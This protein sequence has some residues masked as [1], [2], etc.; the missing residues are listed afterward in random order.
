[1]LV[2]PLTILGLLSFAAA[3]EPRDPTPVASAP[4]TKRS[5]VGCPTSHSQGD[6]LCVGT[7]M[8]TRRIK[9][10]TANSSW[11]V[12]G[13]PVLEWEVVPAY[14]ASNKTTITLWNRDASI[15]P[16]AIQPFAGSTVSLNNGSVFSANRLSADQVPPGTGYWL[17]IDTDEIPG[18]QTDTSFFATSE[19]FEIKPDGTHVDYPADYADLAQSTGTVTSSGV[20]QSSG[21]P[22]SSGPAQ[23]SGAAHSTPV[24]SS[25]G[26]QTSPSP[27]AKPSAAAER[28]VVGVPLA[29]VILVAVVSVL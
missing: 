24:G 27:T 14:N 20:P 22:E 18:P 15:L 21:A 29:A 9:W 12:G 7:G 17:Q 8:N 1:M 26:A 6:T 11:A 13:Y 25:G 3:L 16:K 10:P 4:R 19:E 2:L 5:P 23:S 28:A